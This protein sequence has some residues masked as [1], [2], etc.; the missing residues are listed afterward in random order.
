[1]QSDLIR[2]QLERNGVVCLD[3]TARF[4]GKNHVEITN[5]LTGSRSHILQGDKFLIA[6]G[7]RPVRP[8]QW[9]PLF[10]SPMLVD[11][12]QILSYEFNLPKDMIVI[13][14]GVIGIEYASM[15]A[16]L[17]GTRVTVIDSRRELLEFVDRD[18]IGVLIH[19]MRRQG[20]RF[21]FN[22]KVSDIRIDHD[23]K[24]K[25][26]R[27][28]V[29]TESGKQV[30][31]DCVLYAVGRQG[32]VEH[33]NLDAIGL[34][35]NSRGLLEVD[36][37][38]KTSVENVSAVGDVIGFPALAS[39]SMEQGRL[40]THYMFSEADSPPPTNRFLP[41]G[42]Y[43]IPEISIVGK[44]EVELTH[45][46]V[47]YEVGI[48]KFEELAKGQMMQVKSGFLKL[49]FSSKPPYT[50]LGASAVGESAT[51]IIH[52]A[53]AVLALNGSIEYFRDATFNFPTYAE[54]Y[55]IAALDG[56][57]RLR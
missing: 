52:I 50:M 11:S 15:L 1:M 9:A 13:G 25:K 42:I 49:I 45:Q 24:L 34:K 7:T 53:Q 28:T 27:I 41:Y 23:N 37:Q 16:A 17:P 4:L 54:A 31:G 43:T 46:K 21:K 10:E 30:R 29:D 47:P 12:D 22:E 2:N 35:V 20:A 14:S 36:S 39:T 19:E 18:T 56:I 8:T 33:L 26:D 55:R 3:G 44:T 6:V 38:F 48:A 32:N 57:Q 51:E 40:A 5:D